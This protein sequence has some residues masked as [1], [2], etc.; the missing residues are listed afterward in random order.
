MEDIQIIECDFN[1]P[2]HR[3]QIVRLI[4][5]YMLDP[6]GGEEAMA[7]DVKLNLVDVLENHPARLVLLAKVGNEYAGITNCFINISTFR[8]K[9]YFN[10]HDVTVLKEYRGKGIGRKLLEKVIEIA[11]NRGY[12]KIT[13]EVRE[14]NKNA[15]ALY[16][17]LGFS[18]Y[19]PF[20]HFWTKTL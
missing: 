13:L 15:K 4:S 19:E 14:D 6:M 11:R 10:V 8:A 1:N 20:M 17:S 9:P 3:E 2:E 18:D 16:Q 7:D 5:A 12:C